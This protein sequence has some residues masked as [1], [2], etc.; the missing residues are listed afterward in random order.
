[1]V[2]TDD[3]LLK[4]QVG[5]ERAERD[6]VRSAPGLRCDALVKI[7]PSIRRQDHAYSP[8]IIIAD[9]PSSLF[10]C[11]AGF[12]RTARMRSVATA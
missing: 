8:L 1:M 12:L 10:D 3:A 4:T 6:A 5:C 2:H 7:V 9:A 11:L